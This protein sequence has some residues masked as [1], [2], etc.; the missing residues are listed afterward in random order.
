M[1]PEGIG[2]KLGSL[3]TA[4]KISDVEPNGEVLINNLQILQPSKYYNLM[5]YTLIIQT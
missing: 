2:D 4:V 3:S 1:A 5:S